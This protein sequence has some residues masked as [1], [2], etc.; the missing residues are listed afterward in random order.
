MW[1][2]SIL[3]C[4]VIYPIRPNLHEKLITYFNLKNNLFLANDTSDTTPTQN[5]QDLTTN[6]D[7][8]FYDENTQQY[9]QRE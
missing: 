2:I 9:S 5:S 6:Y 7:N 3:L 4:I 1:S 8:T